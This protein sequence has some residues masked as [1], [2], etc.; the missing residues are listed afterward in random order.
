[1]PQPDPLPPVRCTAIAES[2]IPPPPAP[3]SARLLGNRYRLERRLAVGGMAE[4]WSA[5]DEV[6]GRRVAVKILKPSLAAN[7]RVVQR[8]RREAVAAARLQHHGIVSVFDTVGEGTVEAVVMELVA[9]QTLRRLLDDEPRLSV[10]TTVHIGVCLADALEHAHRA[11]V[12]HRDVKP[13]NVLLTDDG[14]VLLAD[15]GLAKVLADD[16]GLTGDVVLGTAKYLA[17]EQVQ[18]RELD[19]RADLYALGVVLYECLT[20]RVPFEGANDAET[21]VARLKRSPAPVRTLRP[22][23][24]RALEDLVQ[25]LLATDPD[26]RPRR[27]S[28]VRDELSRLEGTLDSDDTAVVAVRDPSPITPLVDR[29]ATPPAVDLRIAR[30][31]GRSWH[32]ALLTVLVVAGMLAAVGAILS[33]TGAGDRL[34]RSVRETVTGKPASTTAPPP[35]T[36]A[37][38]TTVVV[39]VSIVS[40]GE[41]DPSG[42]GKENPNRLT[43]IADGDAATFWSTVCYD[44]PTMMP[45]EGVGVVLQLS[46]PATG[47][48]LA[49]TSI[50]D[51]WSA[52]IY[53]ADGVSSTIDGW[54]TPV[55][56][57]DDLPAGTA[58]FSLGQSTGNHVLVLLTRIGRQP[59]CSDRFP[60]QA[61]L[62]EVAIDG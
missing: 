12:V 3:A 32:V 10:G 5:V 34:L 48:R 8:F 50:G 61:R 29:D 28:M 6:L 46:G 49:V 30:R 19:G 40:T 23:V 58:R 26:D 55:S 1:V 31:G 25:R 24:P 56:E 43:F 51:G 52:S 18:G 13:G 39:P 53:V 9:G 42:D 37:P 60:F 33:R 11:G 44:T 14:R 2:T 35:A 7:P 45:K 4:V 57:Q 20:G 21:A 41:Y 62:A 27:A 38:S 54:G 59:A 15:F 16:D 36:T 17:P 47:H 22:G